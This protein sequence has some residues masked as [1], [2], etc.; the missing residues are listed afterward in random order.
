MNTVEQMSAHH[1]QPATAPLRK[2][3]ESFRCRPDPI[4]IHRENRKRAVLPLDNPVKGRPRCFGNGKKKLTPRDPSDAI[5]E[6][7]PRTFNWLLKLEGKPQR[8]E[9]SVFSVA[10][11]NELPGEEMRIGAGKPN[12]PVDLPGRAQN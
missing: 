2:S 1:P 12:M 8:P 6:L 4:G 11:V 7:A 5:I 10:L 3:F 9:V